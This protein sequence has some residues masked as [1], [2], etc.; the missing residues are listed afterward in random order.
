MDF[1]I[2]MSSFASHLLA[3]I[4]VYSRFKTYETANEHEC[5][6]MGKTHLWG[7]LQ[8]P[9][10]Y[11]L[12]NSVS[13]IADGLRNQ[14]MIFHQAFIRVPSRVF[15][16]KKR[17]KPLMN[18]SSSSGS[19]GSSSSQLCSATRSAA[20]SQSSFWSDSRACSWNICPC[21]G[22]KSDLVL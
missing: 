19:S 3:F 6:R 10:D 22:Q 14:D 15:A 20:L 17:M 8:Y 4:R 21:T 16:V 12:M 11:I 9:D 2:R 1:E 13:D 18:Y 7:L 5:T